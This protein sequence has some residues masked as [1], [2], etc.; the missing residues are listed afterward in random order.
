L[1]NDINKLRE[2]KPMTLTLSFQMEHYGDIQIVTDENGIKWKLYIGRCEGYYNG[3]GYCEEVN[4][5]AHAYIDVDFRGMLT[6]YDQ[7]AGEKI[8]NQVEAYLR[9]LK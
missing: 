5:T 6:I 9:L 8:G 4:V 1:Y 2:E 7:Y 3:H